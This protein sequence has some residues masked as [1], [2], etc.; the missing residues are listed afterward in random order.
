MSEV[1]PKGENTSSILLLLLLLNEQYL[2][3]FLTG[4]IYHNLYYLLMSYEVEEEFMSLPKSKDEKMWG[5][6][7]TFT[8]LVL[9]KFLLNRN[10]SYHHSEPYDPWFIPFST[11]FLVL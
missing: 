7:V 4:D 9:Q 5:L 3:D 2:Y 8:V 1:L 11:I 10:F 6:F